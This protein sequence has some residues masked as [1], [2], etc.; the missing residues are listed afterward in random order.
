[1]ALPLRGGLA[2]TAPFAPKGAG[3]SSHGETVAGL[4]RLRRWPRSATGRAAAARR[5]VLDQPVQAG[6][7]GLREV[8]AG[9][10]RNSAAIKVY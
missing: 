10:A 8:G 2:A 9:G 3:P 6:P 1:M 5:A 4:D 7:L